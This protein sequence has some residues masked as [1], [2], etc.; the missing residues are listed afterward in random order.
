LA[1]EK[2]LCFTALRHG[3]NREMSV[4]P[5]DISKREPD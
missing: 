2:L 1:S 4:T 3:R 5:G